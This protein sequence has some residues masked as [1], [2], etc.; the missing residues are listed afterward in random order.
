M[1]NWNTT[2]WRAYRNYLMTL[3][4]YLD[5]NTTEYKN[6]RKRILWVNNNRVY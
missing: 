3:A 4:C 6:I 2:E 5:I 1:K